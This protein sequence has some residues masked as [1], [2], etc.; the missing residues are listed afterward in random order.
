MCLRTQD[1]GK[2][3]EN[4]THHK[5]YSSNSINITITITIKTAANSY[6]IT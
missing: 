4:K 5:H 2:Q 6:E 3:M 1:I